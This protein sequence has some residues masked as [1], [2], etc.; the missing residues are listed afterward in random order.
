M[1]WFEAPSA[2]KPRKA[3][4]I[5]IPVELARA[6]AKK[7]F[8]VSY[9]GEDIGDNLS[10]VEKLHTEFNID[11]PTIEDADDLD[12]DNYFNSVSEA[13]HGDERWSVEK[14]EMTLGFFSFGKF[15]MYKDLDPEHWKT[16]VNG[17]GFS[18][19]DGLLT[20]GLSEPE[21]K[22][23]DDVDIDE[24]LTPKELYQV[25][26]A[27]SS[28]TLA[29]L[30]S[31]SGRNFVLQGPPGTGKSQTITN[32]IAEC[33]G[34][35]RTV[36]FVSEKMAALDVVKR[37]LDEVGLG[38]AVLELHSHKTKKKGSWQKSKEPCTR[39]APL[40]MILKMILMR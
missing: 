27:D 7:R 1:H 17:E 26:D 19:L 37:R 14:N 21:C 8:K 18:V 2:K 35:G 28:Q 39:D 15:L 36:L 13:I 31:V 32:M 6:S 4:L 29:I 33:L 30:D 10:L 25:K 5:L 9:T 23:H 40:L 20:N 24:I 22:F 38:D 11:F 16:N 34:Q 3:P 12:L